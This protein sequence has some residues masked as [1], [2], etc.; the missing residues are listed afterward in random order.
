MPAK[1]VVPLLVPRAITN[2]LEAVPDVVVHV[3]I[4]VRTLVEVGLTNKIIFVTA[5]MEYYCIN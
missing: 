3:K 4:H 2:V 5:A 1:Q